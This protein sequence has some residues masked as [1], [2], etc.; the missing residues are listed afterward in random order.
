MEEFVVADL[1]T[2]HA[3]L[4]ARKNVDVHVNT[5]V[6]H[7]KCIACVRTYVHLRACIPTCMHTYVHAYLPT[8]A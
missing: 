7:F 2:R 8:F 6:A 5:D 4:H 3:Y 1:I